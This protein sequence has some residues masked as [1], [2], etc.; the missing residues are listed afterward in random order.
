MER[1]M[2]QRGVAS[3]VSSTTAARRGDR[4]DKREFNGDSAMHDRRSDAVAFRVLLW[5]ADGNREF[6]D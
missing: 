4:V 5:R 1:Q 2:Q 3:R 6:V